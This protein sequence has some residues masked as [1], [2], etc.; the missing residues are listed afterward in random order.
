MVWRC[1]IEISYRSFAVFSG[2]GSATDSKKQWL[3]RDGWH[4]DC[5]AVLIPIDR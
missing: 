5:K 1:S 2:V 4:D 3:L